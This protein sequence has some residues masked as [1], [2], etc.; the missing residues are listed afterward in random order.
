MSITSC[1]QPTNG[2]PTEYPTLVDVPLNTLFARAVLDGVADGAL[3]IAPDGGAAHVVHSYGMSLVWGSRVERYFDAVVRHLLALKNRRAP[4]WLQIDPRWVHLP[5][6]AA[7][8]AVPYSSG[9][10]PSET[11]VLADERINFRFD[12]ARFE[13]ARAARSVPPGW[14]IEPADA[15]DFA[16]EWSVTP[17]AFWRD[18]AQ[19]LAAGGGW[20]IVRED[21]GVVGA[22]AFVSF[23]AD[24]QFELG[25]E[26]LPEFRG[27]GL[28]TAVTLHAIGEVVTAGLTPVWACR[29]GNV[30]SKRTAEA[31]GFVEALRVPYFRLP[32]RA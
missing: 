23:R 19:F 5:W 13:A 3:W 14:R 31:V 8:G 20:R 30:A 11:Q 25:I 26:T 16:R 27:L 17:R 10:S 2:Y 22:L 6:A 15:E 9:G 18:A 28:G 29:A 7:L 32:I 12:V 24:D 4:E 21:D 1:P